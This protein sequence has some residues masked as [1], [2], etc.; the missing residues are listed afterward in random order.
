MPECWSNSTACVAPKDKG[1]VKKLMLNRSRP[2]TLPV[3]QTRI[4]TKIVHKLAQKVQSKWPYLLD[5]FSGIPGTVAGEMI[6][7]LNLIAEKIH[8]QGGSLV[9]VKVDIVKAFDRMDSYTL[10]E[11]MQRSP[12]QMD[13][14]PI[15]SLDRYHII[16]NLLSEEMT[17]T[18]AGVRS[19]PVGRRMGIRQGGPESNQV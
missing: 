17:F 10:V 5:Q 12:E 1:P 7:A 9:V 2:L 11:G 4:F 16:D 3:F 19:N 8:Q 13:C 18:V 14:E 6:F 15:H